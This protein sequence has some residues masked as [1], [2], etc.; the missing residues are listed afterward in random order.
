[1][2]RADVLVGCGGV[3]WS[4]DER[5]RGLRHVMVVKHVMLLRNVPVCPPRP[6]RCGV[7]AGIP[8]LVDQ[9]LG[10]E[11]HWLQAAWLKHPQFIAATMAS[12]P[13]TIAVASHRRCRT[14]L[15]EAFH[16]I[17]KPVSTPFQRPLR[18]TFSRFAHKLLRAW[19]V[20]LLL[21][22]SC[23]PPPPPFP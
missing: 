1:M 23:L 5:F 19:E 13:A 15:N 3:R 4:R 2:M 12:G 20:G 6:S 18:D 14:F 17:C 9:I 16:L 7:A 22:P 10:G 11:E 21:S 8:S